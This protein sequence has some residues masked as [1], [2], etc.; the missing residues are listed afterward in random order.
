MGSPR[1][2][3][4]RRVSI[5]DDVN[6][7]ATPPSNN[8]STPPSAQPKDHHPNHQGEDTLLTRATHILATEALALTNLTTL[9]ATSPQAHQ[10]LASA[11]RAIT[12]AHSAHG[13]LLACGVGKSAYIAQKLVATCKSLSI[14]ASYMHACEALHG[15]LG[16]IQDRDVLLFVS[17]SGRTAEL[18]AL[19][20]HVPDSVTVI[21]LT[22]VTRVSDCALLRGRQSS[23]LLPAPISEREE[24]S[25][26][27]AAPTTS[28]TVALA[29][30]DMLALTV[31]GKLHGS[32]TREVFKRNHP[33]GAIGMKHR[34]LESLKASGEDFTVVELPSPSLS[35]SDDC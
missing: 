5:S 19:L 27:V 22:G 29:V 11:V 16:D 31:A 4:R 9:Y 25:F 10:S 30:A 33:G 26:G 35:G 15:D 3:K 13:K 34:E 14:R 7:L 20:P 18:L 8:D 12:T 32:R 17:F 1:P 21:A 28:T 6:R 23:V 2:T 24:E